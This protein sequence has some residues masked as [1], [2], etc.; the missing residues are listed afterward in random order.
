VVVFLVCVA[1]YNVGCNTAN[2]GMGFEL[3]NET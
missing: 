3:R 2:K 1:E